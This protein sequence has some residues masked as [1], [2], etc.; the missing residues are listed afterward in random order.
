MQIYSF[1]VGISS[2]ARWRE[3]PAAAAAPGAGEA[4]GDQHLINYVRLGVVTFANWFLIR[5]QR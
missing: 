1:T 3:V 2:E 5:S 4:S